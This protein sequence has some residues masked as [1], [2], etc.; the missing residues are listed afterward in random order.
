MH[1][2]TDRGGAAPAPAKVTSAVTV[3]PGDLRDFAR[4]LDEVA[5]EVAAV[6]KTLAGS[7]RAD[8]G[9]Y[10]S[11]PRATQAHDRAVRAAHA[12][13]TALRRRVE[14]LAEGT[15]LLSRT[16]AGTEDLNAAEAGAIEAAMRRRKG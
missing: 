9:R 15:L 6:E 13:T 5:H 16:Y 10:H 2:T 1:D 12:N 8:F 7:G 14:E 3:D 11:S 4:F